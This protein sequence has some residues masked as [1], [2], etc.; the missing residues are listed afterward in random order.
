[1]VRLK[2][3]WDRF[4]TWRERPLTELQDLCRSDGDSF[5]VKK[6]AILR[7]KTRPLKPDP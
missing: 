4:E 5:R 2:A 6:F 7:S 3:L 1:M